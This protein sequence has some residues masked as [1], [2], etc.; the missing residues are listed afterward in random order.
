MSEI[1]S[2]PYIHEYSQS[3][4]NYLF[5]C[6]VVVIVE[7]LAATEGRLSVSAVPLAQ[8]RGKTLTVAPV[9]IE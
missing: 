9:S 2:H 4:I 7:L 1:K 3:H 6:T 8:D 5:A